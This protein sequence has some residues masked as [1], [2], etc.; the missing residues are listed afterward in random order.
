MCCT[1]LAENPG[2]KKSPTNRH[3][4]TIAQ[5]CLAISSQLTHVS[6]TGKSLLNSNVSST[7]P[8][9]VANFG[10]LT[11]EIGSGIWDIPANFNGFRALASYC[12]DVAHRRPTKLCTIFRRLL[13]WYT[14]YTFLGTLAPKRNLP[15][16]IFT[17]RPSLAFSYTSSVTART[18]AAGV[19]QSL[20]RGT[21]NGITELSQTAP[22]IFG[23]AAIT[24]DIRSH[25]SLICFVSE[26]GERFNIYSNFV[27]N[28]RLFCFPVSLARR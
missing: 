11:A 12:S 16:A 19:S 6:T 9:N 25:S 1:R 10:P 14:T 2:H 20:W 23:S 4:G 28:V 26:L 18:P 15:A 22:P 8:H 5:I 17:L 13:G 24:L 21:R 3:Q 7:C 27:R